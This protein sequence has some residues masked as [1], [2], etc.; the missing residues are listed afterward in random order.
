MKSIIK[1]LSLILC[2][3]AVV[4]L[5]VACAPAEPP[6]EC[7]PHIDENGDNICDEC[8]ENIGTLEPEEPEGPDFSSTV[9]A[10]KTV[11]Y[12]KG[13]AYSI[14]AENVPEDVE[15]M[16]V[17]NVKES[18][19]EYTVEAHFYYKGVELT[20]KTLT[21]TLTIT[22]ATYD[23]TGVSLPG[24]TVTYSGETVST[25]IEGTLPQGVTAV[26]TYKDADGNGVE[27][28]TDV[29]VYT[30]WA[31]FKGD[32]KNYYTIPP[33]SATVTVTPASVGNISFKDATFAYDG[34]MKSLSVTGLPSDISV[35]YSIPGA[36]APG[37]Y[38]VTARFNTGSNYLP[39]SDMT[40]TMTVRVEN[41][42]S[43]VTE[44][45]KYERLST[46]DYTVVGIEGEPEVVVIPATYEGANVISV[47]QGAFRGQTNLTY[48]YI[49]DG[50]KSIGGAAFDGCSALK[51]AYFGEIT[52]LGQNAF[53]NT[54]LVEIVLPDTLAVIGKGALEG[55][56][57]EK[58]T[59]P[60]VGSG[61]SA[62][63]PYLGYIFGAASAG[64][65][66]NYVPETLTELTISNACVEIYPNALK[67]LSS[68]ETVVIGQG[69]KKIGNN[70][71]LGCTGL[72]D[73]YLPGSVVSIPA[74]VS[75]ENSPFYSC[76]EEL[77]IVVENIA[78]ASGFMKY[79][80]SVSETAYAL[81]VYNK[82]YEEYV[83]NKESF[84]QADLSD[85]SLAGI[86][87]GDELV[88][89]F[90][91]SVLEYTVDVDINTG[92]KTVSA[93]TTS[94]SSS[95]SIV[96]ATSAAN[97]IATVTVV[98]ADGTSTTTYKVTFNITGT[99]NASSSIVIKGGADATVTFVVDDGYKPT[100]TFMKSMMEKYRSLAV[101][102]AVN[103]SKFATLT[104]YDGEDGLSYYEIDENGNYAYTVSDSQQ[105][106]IDFWRDILSVGNS[107]IVSHSHSH[108]FFGMNDAGGTQLTVSSKDSSIADKLLPVGS[109]KKEIYASQQILK[110][111]FAD[112]SRGLLIATPGIT[113]K[114][115]DYTLASAVE[116]KFSGDVGRLVEDT[117]VSTVGGVISLNSNTEVDLQSVVITLP[118]GTV[119][120]TTA[121][122]ENNIIEKGSVIKFSATV[123][124][125]AGAVI[126]TYN[127]AFMEMYGEAIADGVLIGAR[128]TVGG[129]YVAS[130]FVSLETRKSQGSN[131]ITTPEDPTDAEIEAL[132][133]KWKGYIDK[134]VTNKAWTTFCIHAMTPEANNDTDEGAHRITQYQ[135]EELFAY[136]DSLGDQVWV[137]TLTDATLYYH[138]W[139]TSTVTTEFDGTAV[140]VSL[141]DKENDEIYDMA[142]TVKVQ[143]PATWSCAKVGDAVYEIERTARA[144][145]IYVDVAPETT[146]SIVEG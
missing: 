110:A 92:F 8:R 144:A 55:T 78:C 97:N 22:R 141:T 23:L 66:S 95:F 139:S 65:N 125:P 49:S 84:R 99:L 24:L 34:E 60:F 124:L 115:S 111:L 133:T 76:S 129:L 138:Q 122:S 134:A 69:V 121:A 77:L 11:A 80:A 35:E 18:V 137:A 61:H 112:T 56:P 103:T 62:S 96:N 93:L 83:M 43:I 1:I 100:A 106:T 132:I 27:R 21:A 114:T 86:F 130:D 145:Y 126:K 72:R 17:G 41:P 39:I 117:A 5:A 128:S 143:V 118:A 101:S 120:T 15:V 46:G 67:G 48:V 74:N 123:T 91:P 6:H 47:G 4:S 58:L 88:S 70:A 2:L 25:D 71:F 54:G 102:Y 42:E 32:G 13:E 140:K 85:S 135:A 127:T 107:E 14:F 131:M 29:G 90:A 109:L 87:I 37:K 51:Y 53:R 146:V 44:G 142:L 9:F 63:N 64:A 52:A 104:T 79:F 28:I 16:Y 105:A 30:A 119:I 75:A 45:I 89:G 81:V 20:D 19:G 10:D 33:M 113:K 82:T 36:S 68:L 94:A 7:P 31:T 98:S 73:I 38:T 3:L 136:T 12:K 116:Y 108:A 50:I 59:V 40:A 26:I 57:L